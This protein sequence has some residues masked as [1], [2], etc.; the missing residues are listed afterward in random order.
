MVPVD[1]RTSLTI[2]KNHALQQLSFTYTC[3]VYT[4]TLIIKLFDRS[5]LLP[6][7]SK[8]SRLCFVQSRRIFGESI[9]E[10]KVV[11]I[12]DG[13]VKKSKEG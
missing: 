9:A 12:F 13:P 8:M 2:V 1:Q 5:T 11:A 7:H 6:C 3:T 10:M 4:V